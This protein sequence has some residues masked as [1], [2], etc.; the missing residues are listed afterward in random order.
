MMRR[1]GVVLALVAACGRGTPPAPAPSPVAPPPVPL[2]RAAEPR[3]YAALDTAS[4]RLT[5]FLATT[6]R[7]APSDRPGARYGPEDAD[8]L[9]FAA[10]G[11]N[12]P[13]YRLRGTG[14]LPRPGSLRDNAL[15]YR[16]DTQRDFFVTST[17]PVDSNRFVQWEIAVCI[18]PEYGA[19]CTGGHGRK[20]RLCDFQKTK[21]HDY[22]DRRWRPNDGAH[23][24]D[25]RVWSVGRPHDAV[26]LTSVGGDD[27]SHRRVQHQAYGCTHRSRSRQ[28]TRCKPSSATSNTASICR[29]SG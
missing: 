14:D 20:V 4:A 22:H 18:A 9:Q 25:H 19:S 12:V 7:A 21:S 2:P 17:I 11:V 28:R 15:T 3:N 23:G 13:S 8:S 1:A 26:H 29:D 24:I 6:R 5:I 27:A 10:V 16:P